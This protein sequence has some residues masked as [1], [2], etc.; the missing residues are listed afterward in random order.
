MPISNCNFAWAEIGTSMPS[1]SRRQCRPGWPKP[2]DLRTLSLCLW[3]SPRSNRWIPP[4]DRRRPKSQRY[5]R[6]QHRQRSLSRRSFMAHGRGL[7]TGG[8]PKSAISTVSSTTT[9]AQ[10]CTTAAHAS[11][12]AA[13]TELGTAPRQPK[14]SPSGQLNSRRMESR[15]YLGTAMAARSP[16]AQR[17]S[18]CRSD[19]SSYLA[20]P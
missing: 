5:L 1:S 14:S 16:P 3:R 18:A 11:V 2:F 15:L 9:I 7:V 8:D 20:H 6:P 17:I 10:I 19:S 12:G 4:M 13:P